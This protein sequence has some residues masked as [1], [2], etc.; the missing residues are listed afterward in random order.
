MTQSG[1][2]RLATKVELGMSIKDGNL[3]F[4]NIISQE[5][6]DKNISTKEYNNR[7][8]YDCFNS[9]FTADFGSPFLNLLPINIDDI[10]LLYKRARCTPDLIPVFYSVASENSVST[11]TTPSD[12]EQLFHLPSD[13]TNY[14]HAIIKD[15]PYSVSMRRVYCCGKNDEKDATKRQGSI[16]P[17]SMIKTRNVI[18]VMVFPGSIQ[19]RG[20]DLWNI[21]IV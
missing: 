6:E 15:E 16:D 11:L 8:V 9:S 2:F 4:C 14:P 10:P 12:S 5:S 19:I 1:Y 13:D 20:L 3:L 18:T 21:K 7:T 17:R